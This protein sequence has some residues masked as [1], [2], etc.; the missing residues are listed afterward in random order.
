V[1]LDDV[2]GTVDASR[3]Q[4]EALDGGASSKR[5]GRRGCAEQEAGRPRASSVNLIHHPPQGRPARL[6]AQH[7]LNAN[8]QWEVFATPTFCCHTSRQLYSESTAAAVF[9]V[10]PLR[11]GLKDGSVWCFSDEDAQSSRAF[12]PPTFAHD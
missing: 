11:L 10:E 12:C 1:H 6:I 4:P 2:I 8:S 9:W 7:C 3:H 5:Q